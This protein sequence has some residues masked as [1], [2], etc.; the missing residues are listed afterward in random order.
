MYIQE[1]EN[2]L[3]FLY[4][5]SRFLQQQK[6]ALMHVHPGNGKCTLL[7]ILWIRLQQQNYPSMCIQEMENSHYFPYFYMYYLQQ[8]Q[9]NFTWMHVHPGNEKSALLTILWMGLHTAT[10]LHINVHP[11]I[12]T[13]RYFLYILSVGLKQRYAYMYIQE[14]ENLLYFLYFEYACNNKITRKSPSNKR[15]TRARYFPYFQ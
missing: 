4:G 12:E 9:Q 15:K 1:T 10:K 5:F 2:Q 6:Y 7:F 14:T 13:P 8:T 11:G 3:C